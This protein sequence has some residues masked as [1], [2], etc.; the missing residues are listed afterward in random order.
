MSSATGKAT[1]VFNGVF[2]LL[3]T[4]HSSR[5]AADFASFILVAGPL[6]REKIDEE[7]VVAEAALVIQYRNR[8]VLC[9]IAT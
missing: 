5:T 6:R 8:H 7:T 1:S 4:G 9:S 3:G 2:L